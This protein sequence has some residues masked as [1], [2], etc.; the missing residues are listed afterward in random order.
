M[1]I[2]VLSKLMAMF[3]AGEMIL[4]AKAVFQQI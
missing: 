4:K 1:N 2:P 3:N